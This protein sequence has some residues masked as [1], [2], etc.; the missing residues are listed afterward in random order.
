MLLASNLSGDNSQVLSAAPLDENERRTWEQRRTRSV[1]GGGG[2]SGTLGAW[3]GLK[4]L[5]D[6]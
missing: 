6:Y 1:G 3:S 4:W 2:K 5:I